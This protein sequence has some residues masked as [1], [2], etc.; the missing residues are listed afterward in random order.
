[1]GNQCGYR[2]VR[3]SDSRNDQCGK[4][5]RGV[6]DG[7]GAT[8][9]AHHVALLRQPPLGYLPWIFVRRFEGRERYNFPTTNAH[10]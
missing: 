3:V 2:V 1:M 10:A 5:L 4:P 6:V 7:D 9:V 8:C